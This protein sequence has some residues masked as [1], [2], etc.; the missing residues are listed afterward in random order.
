[1]STRFKQLE[2]VDRAAAYE[3]QKEVDRTIQN[4]ANA[5]SQAKKEAERIAQIRINQIR[6]ENAQREQE[7]INKLKKDSDNKFAQQEAKH[8]E[9]LQVLS[10]S[11]QNELNKTVS[12][13][14]NNIAE[15]KRQYGH[16]IKRLR[17]ETTKLIDNLSSEMNRSFEEQ[18]QINSNHQRQIDGIKAEVK[19]LYENI[20]NQK[21]WAKEH[22]VE[23]KRS[24]Q[25][26]END[27][28]VKRF[29]ENEL[30]RVKKSINA[31]EN[32][33]KGDA[34]QS[35][36]GNLAEAMIDLMDIREKATT[37][38]AIFDTLY[39]KALENIK[40]LITRSEHK[41]ENTKVDE[42][43]VDLTFW[44]NGKYKEFE[45]KVEKLR[46]KID[47]AVKDSE[48]D[49]QTLQNILE[50]ITVLSAEEELL[51]IEAV[52]N[53]QL[54]QN[55]V[56][57]ADTIIDKL[58]H[59]Q[60]FILKEE[61]SEGYV[62]SD[63]REGYYATLIDKNN[64][65]ICI[66]I[67]VESELSKADGAIISKVSCQR[68]DALDINPVLLQNN[69]DVIKECLQGKGV[70]TNNINVEDK[71]VFDSEALKHAKLTAEQKE[72][73]EKPRDIVM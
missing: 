18:K 62:A 71:P 65:D 19:N 27:I 53:I 45:D 3:L 39:Q 13:F 16:D 44:T 23:C 26:M 60:N 25:E 21:D 7:I 67:M 4:A 48:I 61:N 30:N 31:A 59:E 63:F 42:T 49:I 12:D 5:A 43:K 10:N 51:V 1:M 41:K 54:S 40:A 56:E 14:E 37:S 64:K 15:V 57:I 73:S 66:T 36:L 55:R 35:A 8:R 33:I 70:E 52:E 11:L 20:D 46:G 6:S 32:L 34:P 47:S 9:A 17:K 50:Q 22:L 2:R 72:K 69:R 28:A 24:I 38:Q 68:D 58:E 29:Q